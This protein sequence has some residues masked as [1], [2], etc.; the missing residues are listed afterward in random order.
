VDLFDLDN[1][2]YHISLRMCFGTSKMGGLLTSLFSSNDDIEFFTFGCPVDDWN[3]MHRYTTPFINQEGKKVYFYGNNNKIPPTDETRAYRNRGC[4]TV[5]GHI[6]NAYIFEEDMN[7]PICH[8]V[9]VEDMLESGCYESGLFVYK[10]E[11]LVE[12]FKSLTPWVLLMCLRDINIK[13]RINHIRNT[14]IILV[15]S[16]E[17]E[18]SE[19]EIT[20]KFHETQ[21]EI[22][23]DRKKI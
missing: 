1:N 9:I 14:Y 13:V 17:N 15:K 16:H 5:V 19:Y 22:S 10:F 12:Y 4:W 23:D 2:K 18:Y 6:T 21:E 20:R 11:N 8:F 3:Q 7:N